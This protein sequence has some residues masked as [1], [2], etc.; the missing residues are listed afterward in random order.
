M[1]DLDESRRLH[2]GEYVDR[3]VRKPLTRLE[4]LV[5]L[6]DLKPTD[7]VADFG[8]GDGMLAQLID[9]KIAAYHGVDF[10]QDFI[11][12][13]RLRASRAGL[14][15]AEFHCA[16]IVA[17]CRANEATFD[18]ATALD[19]SEHIDDAT[20][21]DTFSA[22]R[23]SLKPGGRLYLHTPN[24]DFFLERAKDIGIIP[25]FPE[26]IAVRNLR[27]NTDLL[28]QSGFDRTL[29]RGQALPHYNVLKI[30]HPLRVLPAVGRLFEARLFITCRIPIGIDR[31]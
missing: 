28:A 22:I 26:H 8:C 11:D 25:Q 31:L 13:A 12:A 29:I 17:F 6:M 9:G 14:S 30:V 18:V 15:R 5:P 3:Y 19:F 4:R 1:N 23:Q 16:D 10:S 20:F 24:L 2:S 21:V 27:Q 7:T